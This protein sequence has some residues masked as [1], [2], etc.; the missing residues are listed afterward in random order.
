M[1]QRAPASRRIQHA[2]LC[3]ARA[4]FTARDDTGRIQTSTGCLPFA[5]GPNVSAGARGRSLESTVPT[6]PA[7][8]DRFNRQ[9]RLAP[10]G[11][12]PPPPPRE[13]SNALRDSPSAS[14][15]TPTCRNGSASRNPPG[16]R[17]GSVTPAPELHRASR[18][19]TPG[20]D[21]LSTVANPFGALPALQQE[22]DVVAVSIQRQFR[23][24]FPLVR[25]RSA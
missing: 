10:I 8:A 11:H 18:Q 2:S 1:N 15:S 19:T 22:Q 20:G 24:A 12:I 4:Q 21:H 23:T 13:T 14:D 16:V 25:L 7:W 5:A 17:P 6:K 9:R 3:A